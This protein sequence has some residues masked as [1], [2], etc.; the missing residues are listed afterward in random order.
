VVF[1]IGLKCWQCGVIVLVALRD[2][3]SSL[4]E[5]QPPERPVFG[6]GVT[7]REI[8]DGDRQSQ[9]V[10][11]MISD[12]QELPPCLHQSFQRKPGFSAGLF[13]L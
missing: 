9:S 5:E 8:S 1:R 3:C 4:L 7:G 2:R 13:D 10:A 11:V 12:S 6:A